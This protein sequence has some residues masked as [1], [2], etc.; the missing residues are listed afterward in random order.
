MHYCCFFSY[1]WVGSIQIVTIFVVV[2]V[3][4]VASPQT[5]FGVRLSRIHF[6]DKRTPKDVCGEAIVVVVT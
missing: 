1:L 5:F 4:V 6:R 2:V 3:V